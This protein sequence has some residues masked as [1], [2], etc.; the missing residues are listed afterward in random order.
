MEGDPTTGALADSA[1]EAPAAPVD[2]S[3]AAPTEATHGESTDADTT[4]TDAAEAEPSPSPDDDDEAADAS[5]QPDE[6]DSPEEA[7]SKAE[8]RR[9]RRRARE[10]ER[11]DRAVEERLAARERERA[12]AE[13]QKAASEA[14]ERAAQAYQSRFGSLV[15]TPETLAQLDR[16][17]DGL[18][19]E[20]GALKPYAEGTDLDVL[21]QKQ[22]ALAAKVAERDQYRRNQQT[23]RELD[24]VAIELERGHFL[25]AGR[26]LPQEYRQ[27]FATARTI[28]QALEILEAGVRADEQAKAQAQ[29]TALENEWRGRYEKEVAAHAATRTGAPGAG[30]SPNGANGTGSR[31]G[32]LID[33]LIQQSG[34]EAEFAERAKRGDFAGIDLTR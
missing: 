4:P 32:S 9:E 20:V 2:G 22:T 6:L 18:V 1:P 16:E 7:K 10:Q 8:R 33:R 17:I 34:G 28:P 12:D 24:E 30:P 25:A 5:D 15:G 27:R 23:L 19:T 26:G 3:A 11:I 29:R 13:A 14:Q 31:G 21:D